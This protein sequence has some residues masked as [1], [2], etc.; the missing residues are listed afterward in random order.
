MAEAGFSGSEI[1]NKYPQNPAILKPALGKRGLQI[2]SAWFSSFFSEEGRED[3]TV[4]VFVEKMNFLKAMGAKVVNVCECGHCVQSSPKYVFGRPRFS[5]QQWNATAAGLNQIGKLARGNGMFIAYHHHMGTMVQSAEEIDRFM[6]MT[7]PEWVHLL[8]D[9]GHAFYAG[10]D[11]LAIANKYASRIKNV[12]LKDIRQK[13]LDDVHQYKMSFL[14]SVKAGVFTVPGDGVI[15]FDPVFQTL[16]EANYQGRF[17]KPEDQERGAAGYLW[18]S[19][20]AVGHRHGLGIRIFGTKAGLEWRQEKPNQLLFSPLGQTPLTLE[21]D[22]PEL[23]PSAKRLLRVGAGHPEGYFEAFTNVYTDFAENL[24]AKIEG[25]DADTLIQDFPTLEDGLA[26][27]K[28]LEACVES[29]H[30][31]GGWISI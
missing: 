19:G 18:A 23:Y 22:S 11:A 28:F 2:S 17:E 7:N 21:L 6:E 4:Q 15:N 30:N 8:I 1:G 24:L 10:E 14:N 5:D 9:T 31:G 16:S 25:R 12:H 13:I 3:E 20:V 26:S 27:V 29:S